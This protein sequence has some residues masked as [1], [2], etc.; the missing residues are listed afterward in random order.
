MTMRTKTLAD[1]AAQLFARY[2]IIDELQSPRLPASSW[3][4][5]RVATSQFVD[6]EFPPLREGAQ[7]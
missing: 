4:P 3:R 5:W 7:P 2:I 6:N 1:V